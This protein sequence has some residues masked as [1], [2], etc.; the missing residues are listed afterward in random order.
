MQ[1]YKKNEKRPPKHQPQ[2]SPAE[3]RCRFA[4]WSKERPRTSRHWR[5]SGPIFLETRRRLG[6][7]MTSPRD[8]G[9]V[10]PARAASLRAVRSSRSPASISGS[11]IRMQGVRTAP[12]GTLPPLTRFSHKCPM[13]RRRLENL[14]NIQGTG[15][16]G[17]QSA[18]A[19]SERHELYAGAWPML[20]PWQNVPSTEDTPC[21]PR[22]P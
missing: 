19:P 11:E 17:R 3:T 13:S 12:H 8:R 16:L 20:A 15:R 1:L 4:A 22:C 21:W 14:A 10:L 7:G 6:G 9:W 5:S 18:A 2:S